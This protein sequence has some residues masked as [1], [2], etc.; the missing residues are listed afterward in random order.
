MAINFSFL[1]Y[2][3]TNFFPC[4][5][6]PNR[7][8]IA[9][10]SK[11]VFPETKAFVRPVMTKENGGNW[12][13]TWSH[14]PLRR[15]LLA[16]TYKNYN[17]VSRLSLLCFGCTLSVGFLWLTNL[18]KNIIFMKFSKLMG[19]CNQ[20]VLAI[21]DMKSWNNFLDCPEEN[22]QNGQTVYSNRNVL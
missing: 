12:L 10:N 13:S 4:I 11:L 21:Q 7:F 17:Y 5:L 18:Y 9:S 15:F 2:A 19:E 8:S 20:T 22:M 6:F 3:T 16:N 1:P 14:L